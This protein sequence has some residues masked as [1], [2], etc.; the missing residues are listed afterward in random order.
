[1]PGKEA[2]YDWESIGE[3][4]KHGRGKWKS[5]KEKTRRRVEEW[6]KEK[7]KVK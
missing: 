3:G 2:G 5:A 7:R 4:L 6:R 1:M